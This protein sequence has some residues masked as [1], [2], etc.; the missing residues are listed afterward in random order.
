MKQSLEQR[1]DFEHCSSCSFTEG[2]CSSPK[3]KLWYSCGVVYA[4]RRMSTAPLAG[5]GGGCSVL[6]WGAAPFAKTSPI[7]HSLIT[8]QI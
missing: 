6:S 2:L 4:V 1:Q 5:V 3:P 8:F 7:L